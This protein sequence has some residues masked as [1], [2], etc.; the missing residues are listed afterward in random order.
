MNSR[1][2]KLDALSLKQGI[3]RMKKSPGS[4]IPVLT[5]PPVLRGGALC[6]MYL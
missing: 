1:F 2:D 6:W 4:A 3:Y 5:T